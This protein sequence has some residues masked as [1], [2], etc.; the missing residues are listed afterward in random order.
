[1]TFSSGPAKAYA[2]SFQINTS[3][4]ATTKD[5]VIVHLLHL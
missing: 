4:V 1:M 5:F 2:I 3:D